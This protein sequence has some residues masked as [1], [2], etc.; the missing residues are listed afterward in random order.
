MLKG[1][2]TEPKPASPEQDQLTATLENVLDYVWH[3]ISTEGE[4]A[5]FFTIWGS[6]VEIFKNSDLVNTENFFSDNLVQIFLA[7]H[8]KYG[9][10]EFAQ[11]V[12]NIPLHLKNDIDSNILKKHRRAKKALDE[13]LV[14][15]TAGDYEGA[16]KLFSSFMHLKSTHHLAATFNAILELAIQ[17]EDCKPERFLDYTPNSMMG[18]KLSFYCKLTMHRLLKE[19][20]LAA[21][22]AFKEFCSRAASSSADFKTSQEI[23]AIVK[24]F[25]ADL[26]KTEHC[27]LREDYIALLPVY[28]KDALMSSPS[29]QKTVARTKEQLVRRSFSIGGSDVSAGLQAFPGHAAL[30]PDYKN[31]F[32]E[33]T[34]TTASIPADENAEITLKKILVKV[35]AEDKVEA[36]TIQDAKQVLAKLPILRAEKIQTAFN[37]AVELNTILLAK[38][39]PLGIAVVFD[40]LSFDQTVDEL[41]TKDE[42][43]RLT[44]PLPTE[45]TKKIEICKIIAKGNIPADLIHQQLFSDLQDYCKEIFRQHLEALTKSQLLNCLHYFL[46]YSPELAVFADLA[47]LVEVSVN[48]KKYNFINEAFLFLAPLLSNEELD[49]FEKLLASKSMEGDLASVHESVKKIILATKQARFEEE[50]TRVRAKVNAMLV[51]LAEKFYDFSFLIKNFTTLKADIEQYL[52][53]EDQEII[54]RISDVLKKVQESYAPE[55]LNHLV[56][57]LPSQ[58]VENQFMDVESWT[59]SIVL[60]APMPSFEDKDPTEWQLPKPPTPEQEQFIATLQ[61]VLDYLW[62][63]MPSETGCATFLTV[64]D[65]LVKVIERSGLSKTQNFYKINDKL[66]EILLVIY[67]H[68][69]KTKVEG[70]LPAFLKKSFYKALNKDQQHLDNLKKALIYLK[71]GEYQ[72]VHE[73]FSPSF[74]GEVALKDDNF[75]QTLTLF[76][77]T[78]ISIEASNPERFIAE[79]SSLSFKLSLSQYCNLTLRRLAKGDYLAARKAFK[80]FCLE[81]AMITDPKNFQDAVAVAK[82]FL[83]DLNQSGQQFM[84]ES[85]QALLPVSLRNALTATAIPVVQSDEK[86]GLT[87]E[88]LLVNV[89]TEEKIDGIIKDLKDFSVTLAKSRTGK[90][91]ETFSLV[92]TINAILVAKGQ[93]AVDAS[94]VFELLCFVYQTP[95]VSVETKDESQTVAAKSDSTSHVP[96]ELVQQLEVLKI[97]AKCNLQSNLAY[98][99]LFGDLQKAC[100]R[101]LKARLTVKTEALDCFNYFLENF[102]LRLA[103]FED[104]KFLVEVSCNLQSFEKIY[105]SFL[106]LEPTLSLKQLLSLQEVLTTKSA[107]SSCDQD[108]LSFTQR[109]QAALQA[110]TDKETSI[111][112]KEVCDCLRDLGGHDSPNK[113]ETMIARMKEIEEYKLFDDKEVVATLRLVLVRTKWAT[114]GKSIPSMMQFIPDQM[115][116]HYP[117]FLSP[118]TAGKMKHHQFGLSVRRLPEALRSA[119]AVT[120]AVSVP[121]AVPSLTAS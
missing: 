99:Q 54:A 97:I 105:R 16:F 30:S 28:L 70:R 7:I 104:F 115:K 5:T 53:F 57:L 56:A 79:V 14:K 95:A 20:Y 101:T 67:K 41:E 52:L 33:P 4:F 72:R 121:T 85:Y 36:A 102:Q 109:I 81:S 60:P 55:A 110:R 112:K 11:R 13:A 83:A 113:T 24:K 84:L 100:L 94:L 45:L 35:L 74:W 25:F 9:E 87:R 27:H 116:K 58:I 107:A 92:I 63:E 32:Q 15:F 1:A 77:E 51:T 34:V 88:K 93:T 91:Q 2:R 22:E 82:K 75:A 61:Q 18:A 48:L 96:L 76:F 44:S 29:I 119:S 86:Q 19:D 37:Y 40:L 31:E 50:R 117:E 89:L 106:T 12:A 23:I 59:L 47:T 8:N 10:A 26:D 111:F 71:A 118:K 39:E 68:H 62:S 65:P 46:Q 64:F 21:K 3:E 6:L 38:G 73:L 49:E 103:S 69:D 90:I 17:N 108:L 98:Q 42:K 80:R 78:V 120:V 43:E 66:I 114:S